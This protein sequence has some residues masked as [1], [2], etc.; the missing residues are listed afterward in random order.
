M[1][2]ADTHYLEVYE[3]RFLDKTGA[4]IEI[5]PLRPG[6]ERALRNFYLGLSDEALYSF[7]NFSPDVRG[8]VK[9]E[10]MEQMCHEQ[11][12][13]RLAALDDG[14]IIGVGGLLGYFCP[15][16]ICE[17]GYL[18]SDEYQQKG[19]GSVLVEMLIDY[20][21]KYREEGWIYAQTSLYNVGSIKLL[22][23]FGFFV[24][25]AGDGGIEWMYK[26]R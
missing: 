25:R 18:I 13:L 7:Y 23:K 9:N 26:V 3:R 22:E 10:L 20:A 24:K 2:A 8:L 19:I 17:I 21:E 6:D 12:G 5:R 4:E 11:N 15:G 14:E 16:E 1:N